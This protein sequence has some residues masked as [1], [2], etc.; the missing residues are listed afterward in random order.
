MISDDTK[1][2]LALA[3]ISAIGPIR[4]Q[5]IINYF[6]HLGDLWSASLSTIIDAG[7]EPKIAE[8]IISQRKTIEPDGELEKVVRNNIKIIKITDM[9]YPRLLKEIYSPPPLIYFLGE[10]DLKNDFTL[11]VVG[12]R[13]ITSYGR[14][15]TET[16]VGQLAQAGLTIVSGLALGID[17]CAHQTT[18]DHQGKTIAVLGS[19][20]NQIY[21]A[22]NRGL[23]KKIIEAGG[24]VISDF[25]LG[26]LPYKSNFPL[27]NRIIAGLS[28]GTLV[29]E[30]GIK[31]GALITA[32]Y[33]LEQN[34]E[35]FAVPGNIFA[36]NAIGPNELIK[37][38]AKIVIEPRDVLETLNLE[39]AKNFKEI[40]NVIADNE[41]EKI[42]LEILEQ[43]PIHVDK[44]AQSA[45]LNISLVNSCLALMEMK[46]L[47][48]NL[49]GQIYYKAR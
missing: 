42:I 17:A 41:T 6:P 22:A 43:E 11:A 24:A 44:L 15:I 40:K 49:G 3:K 10:L 5:R 25:P 32:R 26:T 34:R 38:G 20:L 2:W 7:I 35:V 13:K 23:A 46:G 33:A 18:L 30:A 19:G 36:A 9:S 28:L 4:W 27:R 1:Y 16:L 21:P 45:K 8:Q 48:K 12:T 47:V 31:S 14:Q 29:M 37:S 39:D